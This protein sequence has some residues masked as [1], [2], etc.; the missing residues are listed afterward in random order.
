VNRPIIVAVVGQKGGVGK[1]G[2]AAGISQFWTDFADILVIDMDPQCSLSRIFLEAFDLTVFEV[3]AGQIGIEQAIYS[4][5][6]QFSRWLK[7][8]PSSSKLREMDAMLAGRLDRFHCVQDALSNVTNFDFIILDCP[9]NLGILSLASLV[10]AD[11]ALIPSA[12][13]PMSFDQVQIVETTIAAIKQR[14]NPKIVTLP[15][16][17][18]LFDGRNRLDQEVVSELQSRYETF[19][20]IVKRRVRIKEEFANRMPCTSDDLKA[21]SQEIFERISSH[22]QKIHSSRH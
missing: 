8:V 4:T 17:L 5:L 12:T 16:V 10:A 2:I 21:I 7:V 13:E 14:L 3:L 6:P 22:E 11:Y 18:T 1:T 19:H 20:T 15:L 9:G